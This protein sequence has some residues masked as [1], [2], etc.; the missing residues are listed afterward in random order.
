MYI[1]VYISIYKYIY[2]YIGIPYWPYSVSCDTSNVIL[3][4]LAPNMCV[5]TRYVF[6]IS[7][8][9]TYLCEMNTK[10]MTF[11]LWRVWD[12]FLL[13]HVILGNCSGVW[14]WSGYGPYGLDVVRYGFSVVAKKFWSRIWV[15]SK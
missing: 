13:A 4:S 5:H 15:V 2:A 10:G 6:F 12:H 8:Y 3:L 11:I 1:Y 9:R 7:A 14:K